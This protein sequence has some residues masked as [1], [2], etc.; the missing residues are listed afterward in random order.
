VEIMREMVRKNSW[1]F[2]GLV[3]HGRQQGVFRREVDAAEAGAALAAG[4][5]GV[6]ASCYSRFRGG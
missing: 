2:S 1:F 4:Y 6:L 3:Q 5:S